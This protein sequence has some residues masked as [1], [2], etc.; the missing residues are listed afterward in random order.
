MVSSIWG[1]YIKIVS[2]TISIPGTFNYVKE[3]HNFMETEYKILINESMGN[4]MGNYDDKI[5]EIRF[6]P[7]SKKEFP[8]YDLVKEF[9]NLTLQERK[10]L[11]YYKRRNIKF[12][13]KI[14]VL[15]QYDGKLISSAIMVGQNN[16]FNNN[17]YS[18]YYI[19][20]MESLYVFEEA[21]TRN[22]FNNIDDSFKGFNQSTRKTNLMYLDLIIE[23]I[24][25][26]RYLGKHEVFWKKFVDSF[27]KNNIFNDTFTKIKIWNRSYYDLNW[28]YKGIHICVRHNLKEMQIK[29]E[30]YIVDNKGIYNYLYNNKN[31]I[32]SKFEDEIFYSC[33]SE[34]ELNDKKVRKVIIVMQ[35]PEWNDKSAIEECITWIQNTSLKMK[36]IVDHIDELDEL[37]S[38]DESYLNRKNTIIGNDFIII[39]EKPRS[40]VFEYIRS[41]FVIYLLKSKEICIVLDPRIVENNPML[42]NRYRV[43]YHSTALTKFPKEQNKGSEI[44]HY[45]YSVKFSK[46]SDL[47]IFLNSAQVQL[48]KLDESSEEY[49]NSYERDT[50]NKI[51]YY[52]KSNNNMI[53]WKNQKA[54]KVFDKPYKNGKLKP[55]RNPYIAIN[56]LLIAKNMCEY[57]HDHKLFMRKNGQSTYTEA[58][59]L[60]QM[61]MH[62]DFSVGLDIEQNIVSLCS[63]CHN[64]L[65]YG[66]FEDKK[67]ILEKLYS[68]RQLALSKVGIELS[69][70]NKLLQYYK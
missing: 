1:I 58:H 16:D 17:D 19:F 65:H 30:L 67:P 9:L 24:N 2:L 28:K 8:T 5:Q 70:L 6:L 61:S 48:N 18:G 64:I 55:K 47:D 54:D 51:M 10:G 62:N 20:N 26:K 4:K 42:K 22:E 29:V 38:S 37:Q 68:K 7:M 44:I 50:I 60:V 11:Y 12:D 43:K 21:I 27:D 31:R 34:G 56:A 13:N 69:T 53:I 63:H 23:I 32:Q 41:N 49:I 66:R 15:F 59:H 57:D 25:R 52:K 39:N 14:L 35:L 40:I 36:N 3:L 33:N 45:G 46:V